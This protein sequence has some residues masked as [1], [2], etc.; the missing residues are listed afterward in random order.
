MP[1]KYPW[2][3]WVDKKKD[4]EKKHRDTGQDQDPSWKQSSISDLKADIKD[5]HA[6]SKHYHRKAIQS[7]DEEQSAT[8]ESMSF[9]EARHEENLKEMEKDK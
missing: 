2:Q 1:K 7:T 4:G 5:E 8:Y 9:D 3:R 6:A